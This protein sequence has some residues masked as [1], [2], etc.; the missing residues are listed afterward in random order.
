MTE[1][2]RTEYDD[3]IARLRT[4]EAELHL[5]LQGLEQLRAEVLCPFKVGDILTNQAGLRAIVKTISAGVFHDYEMRGARLRKDGSEGR[6]MT[7]YNWD[8]WRGEGE[9]R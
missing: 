4:E 2:N 9:V 6:M 1:E 5:R 7:L 8:N 3:D